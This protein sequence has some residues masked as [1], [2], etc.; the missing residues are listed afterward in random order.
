MCFQNNGKTAQAAKCIKSIITT[1]MID[2]VL[3]I[4]KFEQQCVVFKGM[5]HSPRLKYHVKTI[6]IGQYLR[7]NALFENKFIKKIKK[8]Y[9]HAGKCDDQQKFKDI[10]EADMISTPERFTDNSP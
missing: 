2:S 8:L 5:S 4:D 9:K 1:K 7:N 10:I 6:D 3:L